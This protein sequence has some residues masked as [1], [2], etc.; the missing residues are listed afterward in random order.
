MN[1]KMAQRIK[2]VAHP[3]LWDKPAVSL[4]SKSAKWRMLRELRAWKLFYRNLFINTAFQRG[5]LEIS[6]KKNRFKRFFSRR[7]TSTRLKPGVNENV[8]YGATWKSALL[9]VAWLVSS[10]PAAAQSTTG[11][12]FASFQIIGQRNIFDPNRVPHR[13]TGATARVVDSFSFVGTLS[14]AKGTFA[15]F[16]GTSPDFRKVL[17]LDG[18]IAGFKVAAITPKSVKLLSETNAISGTNEIVLEVGTQIRRN[19]DGQWE[20]SSEPAAYA[21]TGGT[22]TSGS[23]HR[24]SGRM[25]F[26]G[27]SRSSMIT[28]GN[29]QTGDS[30]PPAPDGASDTGTEMSAPETTPPPGGNDALARLMQRRAQEEQQL[31]QGQ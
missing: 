8:F 2:P 11:T 4:I 18:S 13:R 29:L 9:T 19:D 30:N 10:F 17:E 15:F 1:L 28:T 25:R 21:S 5:G 12:D 6:R 3:A 14:Y 31:G 23:R 26:D 24:A 16:D 20:V 7:A 22:S 27:F